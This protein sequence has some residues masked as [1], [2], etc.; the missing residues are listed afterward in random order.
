MPRAKHQALHAIAD[1][2][3]MP[4]ARPLTLTTTTPTTHTHAP[5]PP[6]VTSHWVTEWEVSVPGMWCLLLSCAVAVV[7]NISQ[8]LCLGR[9][10]ATSF[11][12]RKQCRAMHPLA[13]W[14]DWMD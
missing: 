3:P 2:Q 10:S 14:L 11:Q 7:V 12:V 13:G 6:Q 1:S 8:Y 9:F 5:L 4:S